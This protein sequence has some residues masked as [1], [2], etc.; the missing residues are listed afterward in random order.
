M[1]LKD[2]LPPLSPCLVLIR[3]DHPALHGLSYGPACG[4]RHA[5]IQVEPSVDQRQRRLAYSGLARVVLTGDDR[6]P[7]K[8]DMR[9]SDTTD[10]HD[11]KFHA[12]HS[13]VSRR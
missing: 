8:P 1:H 4:I 12:D 9:F 11:L 7:I 5:P 3:R 2:R 6:D 10:S 13:A